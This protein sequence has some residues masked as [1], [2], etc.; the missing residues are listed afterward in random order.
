MWFKLPSFGNYGELGLGS[1]REVSSMLALPCSGLLFSALVI[2]YAIPE[3]PTW[4]VL[5]VS[6]HTEA[7]LEVTS[8]HAAMWPHATWTYPAHRNLPSQSQPTPPT[9][10]CP[11]HHGLPC[12][13]QLAPPIVARPTHQGWFPGSQQGAY[14]RPRRHILGVGQ[15]TRSGTGVTILG[16]EQ[17]CVVTA[18][19][20]SISRYEFGWPPVSI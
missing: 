1:A 9:M 15:S 13:L 17:N 7:S 16:G 5:Q 10:T 4:L 11:A 14:S 6:I 19:Y 20:T 2:T 3:P 8:C 12:S 18:N